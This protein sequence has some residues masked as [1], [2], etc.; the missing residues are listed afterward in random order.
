MTKKEFAMWQAVTKSSQFRWTE[1]EIY[2]LNG[3]GAFYYTGGEDGIYMKIQNDGMLEA[4][5]YEG[6]IPHIGEAFFKPVVQRQCKDYNEAYTTAMEAGGKQFLIDMLS[7]PFTPDEPYHTNFYCPLTVYGE[8]P[9][10]DEPEE[11][12]N[13]ILAYYEDE[14]RDFLEK[15]LRHGGGTD[16][17][18][19][20]H[21]SPELQEK[22][23]SVRFDIENIR[24]EV[25]GCIHCETTEP[26]SAEEKEELRGYCT[27]QASDGFGEGLEQQPFKTADGDLYVSYWDSGDGWFMLDDDEFEQHL[28]GGQQMGGL[29]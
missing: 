13:D 20:F 14:F 16:L 27:G 22:L 17:A 12:D 25:Y 29:Q 23:T 7:Q 26:L 10:G 3:R 6:A 5:N 9:Y 11:L 24:N 19:Y 21:G 1:D 28:S 18:E 8:H 15:D 4:G 2:R